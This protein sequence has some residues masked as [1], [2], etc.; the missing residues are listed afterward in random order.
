MP[1]FSSFSTVARNC[2]DKTLLVA[3][4]TS[5]DIVCHQRLKINSNNYI[6]ERHVD[7]RRDTISK[8]QQN[9]LSFR[10]SMIRTNLE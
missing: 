5:A 4:D 8:N 10:Q 7:K 1:L 2:L 9:Y 3:K 6:F